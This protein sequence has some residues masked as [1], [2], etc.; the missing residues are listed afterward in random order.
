MANGI[1]YEIEE[2]L[3]KDPDSIA[4]AVV[5]RILLAAQKE[6]I[7][8]M[9]SNSERL[10]TLEKKNVVSWDW[11]LNRILPSLV[12]GLLIFLLLSFIPANWP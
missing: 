3:K 12:T 7:K 9:R 4:Q 6:T 10:D 5:N 8:G 2:L 1:L 11:F